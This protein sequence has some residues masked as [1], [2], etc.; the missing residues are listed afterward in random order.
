MKKNGYALKSTV[1]CIK[2]NGELCARYN[3]F[4]LLI[5]NQ[6]IIRIVL[7]RVKIF[8]LETSYGAARSFCASPY[9]ADG[10]L[11]I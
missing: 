7:K 5:V 2:A 8:S 6:R 10:W 9:K 11:L 3:P 4:L 1:S